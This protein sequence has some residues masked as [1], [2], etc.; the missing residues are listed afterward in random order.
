MAGIGV[1]AKGMRSKIAAVKTAFLRLS[2][3]LF[4]PV[5]NLGLGYGVRVGELHLG[6]GGEIGPNSVIGN[7]IS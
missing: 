6:T 5:I 7:S 2:I 4:S 3:G 1:T